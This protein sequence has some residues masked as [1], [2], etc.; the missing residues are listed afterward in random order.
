M[1]E[2]REGVPVIASFFLYSCDPARR[3]P[4]LARRLVRFAPVM[5]SQSS[6]RPKIR[7]IDRM[8]NHLSGSGSHCPETRSFHGSPVSGV[9]APEARSIRVFAARCVAVTP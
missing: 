3:D 9:D 6:A 7:Y 5:R 2:M 8:P 4:N 1:G